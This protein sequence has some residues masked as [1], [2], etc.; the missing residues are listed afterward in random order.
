MK[1]TLAK[2]ILVLVVL[3][4]GYFVYGQFYQHQEPSRSDQPQERAPTL[5]VPE[6]WDKFT[7][8]S[9]SFR[10]PPKAKI[11][12]EQG[13]VRLRFIGPG[14][15]KGTEITDG[16]TLYIG[17]DQTE[18]GVSIKNLAQSKYESAVKNMKAI[19]EPKQVNIGKRSGYQF[20]VQTELGNDSNRIVMRADNNLIFTIS[21][22]ISDPNDEGYDQLVE[23]IIRSLE[24]SR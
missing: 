3:V 17:T 16:F 2:L 4:G 7:S 24:L 5:S 23:K 12:S 20:V 22:T 11:D 10:H 15:E 9:F 6:D 13:R 8:S 1:Q 14:S 21:Y 19:Q 18:E